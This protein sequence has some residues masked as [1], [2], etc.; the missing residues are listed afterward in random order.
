MPASF[1]ALVALVAL[2]GMS[3]AIAQAPPAAAPAAAPPASVKELG[4]DRY[5]IGTIIVDR[6]AGQFTVPGR[7]L[8]ID[9]APLEYIAVGRAGYKGYESLLELDAVGTEFNLACI[10]LGLDNAAVR[11][12]DFQ[13]DRRPP[14][15][16]PV[17]L[18]LRWQTDGTTVEVPL[19]DALSFAQRPAADGAP[20]AG[21]PPDDWVYTGSFNTSEDGR[22]AADVVGTIVGFVHDPASI[23]EHRAGLGIGAY[24][25]VQGNRQLLPP[26]GSPVELIVTV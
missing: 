11:R 3:A 19:R 26:I 25:S 17:V 15:G 18:G 8:H 6:K 7:I 23:I 1:N 21:P 5:Q 20:A 2:T 24:G 14:E 16:P 9:D 4:K 10:L 13:F 12:P 22:Y